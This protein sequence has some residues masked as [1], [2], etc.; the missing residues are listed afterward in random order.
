M[1]GRHSHN[2][3]PVQHDRYRA[4][5][6]ENPAVI[7]T[8]KALSGIIKDANPAACEF[9]GYSRERFQA[10]SV[11][12]LNVA[13]VGETRRLLL[14]L[15][16]GKNGR[17]ELRQRLSDG[18]IRNMQCDA[19]VFTQGEEQLLFC[20]LH[21]VTERSSAEFDAGVLSAALS[22]VPHGVM[23]TDRT[24]TI[25]WVNACLS[26]M[27]G[28]EPG[29][30]VGQN[31]NML[32]SG[33]QTRAQYQD[34]WDTILAGRTWS[35]KLVNRR[36]DGSHYP[37]MQTI[38]PVEDADG[39]VRYFIAMKQD[40]TARQ[41]ARQ[42]LRNQVRKQ[43]A[44]AEFSHAALRSDDAEQLATGA[45]EMISRI[46]EPDLVNVLRLNLDSDVFTLWA[47]TGWPD[48]I[49]G[50]FRIANDP[51]D[52]AGYTML[53]DEPLISPDLRSETRFRPA[54]LL[55]ELGVRLSIGVPIDN[56][57]EAYG[58]LGVHF[59]ERKQLPAEDVVFLQAVANTL[60]AAIRR[61]R[62]RQRLE[63]NNK[64]LLEA[65]DST[66]EGLAKAL[67][68]R[69]HETEGH[70]RRVT[71]LSEALARKLGIREPA[72]TSLRRG[73]LLHDIGKMGLPDAI[74]HKREPLTAAERE[75]MQQ[76]PVLARDLLA[77]I[78]FL[79]NSADIPYSHHEKWD[80]TGY[81]EG[82]RGEE[83]P[84]HARIFA[85]VDVYDALTSDRPYRKAWSA[86]A[87]LEYIRDRAGTHF[88]PEICAAFL[89]L[90]HETSA[91]C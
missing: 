39:N 30:L 43:Q 2:N 74:L 89:E 36:K 29:E 69:D 58:I 1:A 20:I 64:D 13:P 87:A 46:L 50:N 53:S 70:S 80:G 40:V 51:E 31:P 34:L 14:R 59:T 33:A 90:M 52:H 17:L 23:I 63:A 32:Q 47:G 77:G 84:L 11:F 76:H 79:R 66:I 83:I 60:A 42:Q 4:V 8:V 12:D 35:G 65:Y 21:D 56:A 72:L 37:E 54:G 27:T 86:A 75:Q 41:A 67:D 49:V 73:A 71:G 85:V 28:Y 15:R 68:L 88:D 25:R 48:D 78:S 9:Y 7:L 18:T 24:G 22:A 19:S 91:V 81:P 38:T 26:I 5:F 44:L 3:Y 16:A 82:L 10:L 62:Y 61:S 57:Q 45:S 55:L 6:E